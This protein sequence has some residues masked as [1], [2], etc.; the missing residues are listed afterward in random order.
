MLLN[1]DDIF[2]SSITINDDPNNNA[3]INILSDIMKDNAN[4]SVSLDSVALDL[5]SDMQYQDLKNNNDVI[6]S[7]NKNICT[8]LLLITFILSPIIILAIVLYYLVAY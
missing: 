1:E 4:P 6:V 7:K 5:E 8:Y 2:S 3:I